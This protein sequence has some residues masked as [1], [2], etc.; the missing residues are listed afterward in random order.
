MTEGPV[1]LLGKLPS[2]KSGMNSLGMAS[3]AMV[4][5]QQLT[6]ERLL[7]MIAC[8][9]RDRAGYHTEWGL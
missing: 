4:A 7:L 6:G 8:A 3:G 5:A 1:R 9:Y 2:D